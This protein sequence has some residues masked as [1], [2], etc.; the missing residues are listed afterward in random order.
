MIST[1]A[2]RISAVSKVVLVL[3]RSRR[4]VRVAASI[5]K[6]SAVS[7]AMRPG[8]DVPTVPAGS[9]NSRWS[10]PRSQLKPYSI[11][12]STPISPASRPQNRARFER[13]LVRPGYCVTGGGSSERPVRMKHRAVFGFTETQPGRM[14]LSAVISSAQP[15]RTMAPVSR[16]SAPARDTARVGAA[17][18]PREPSVVMEQTPQ[19]AQKCHHFTLKALMASEHKSCLAVQNTPS[20]RRVSICRIT[21]APHALF[22]DQCSN[23]V[24]SMTRTR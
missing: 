7:G 3:R 16:A 20:E 23:A 6:H 14:L 18:R 17:T 11:S 4:M 2:H 8:T 9:G 22:A 15:S 21:S 10:M 19:F 5:T 1:S 24:G 12:V 13:M